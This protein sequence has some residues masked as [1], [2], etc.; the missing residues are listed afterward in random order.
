MITRGFMKPFHDRN[1]WRER[2]K[3][4]DEAIIQLAQYIMDCDN[5]SKRIYYEMGL[6]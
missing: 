2:I 4:L 5:V 6:D 3:H 1:S